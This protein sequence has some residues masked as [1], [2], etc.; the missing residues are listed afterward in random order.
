MLK[1]YGAILGRVRPTPDD[2]V[3]AQVRS[4]GAI[5]RAVCEVIGGVD[6]SIVM[7]VII[8]V[9]SRKHPLIPIFGAE[10]R[11]TES[12]ELFEF[13]IQNIA[14]SMHNHGIRQIWAAQSLGERSMPI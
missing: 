11:T 1:D 2:S 3:S 10:H 9:G 4:K 12:K 7:D 6:H 13:A 8:F 5:V 14:N